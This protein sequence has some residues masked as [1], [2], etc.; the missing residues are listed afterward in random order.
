MGRTWRWQAYMTRAAYSSLSNIW[1]L[2]FRAVCTKT[3]PVLFIAHL[4][5]K[6]FIFLNPGS[7]GVGVG[8]TDRVYEVWLALSSLQRMLFSNPYAVWGRVRLGSAQTQCIPLKISQSKNTCNTATLQSVITQQGCLLYAQSI[9]T[10]P[11]LGRINPH[12]ALVI[13]FWKAHVMY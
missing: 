2:S 5:E 11:Q 9:H 3:R 1:T 12:K 10:H 7:I 13:K 4:A 6:C 8:W